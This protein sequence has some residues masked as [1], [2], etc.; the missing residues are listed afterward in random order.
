MVWMGRSRLDCQC[1]VKHQIGKSAFMLKTLFMRPWLYIHFKSGT[2]N[3]TSE[4][5][6]IDALPDDD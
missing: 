4:G 3:I 5:D 2:F 1:G 6:G